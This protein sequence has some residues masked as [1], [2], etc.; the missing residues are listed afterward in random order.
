MSGAVR[1]SL[2]SSAAEAGFKSSTAVST[3][4]DAAE[5]E[6][7]MR[8]SDSPRPSGP[9]IPAGE[10][11]PRSLWFFANCPAGPPGIPS[12]TDICL[13]GGFQNNRVYELRYRATGSPGMG[14][15]KSVVEG[16]RVDLG[17]R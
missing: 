7:R 8:P 3:D 14:D 13:A 11:V 15:R 1:R 2:S 17:G 6:L 16:K 9:A 4:R 5:A 12:T 10:L